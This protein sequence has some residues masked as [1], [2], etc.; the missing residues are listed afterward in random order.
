MERTSIWFIWRTLS[1][2]SRC[3]WGAG[4]GRGVAQRTLVH[5]AWRSQE[6]GN[7]TSVRRRAGTIHRVVSQ[8]F[9]KLANECER[10]GHNPAVGRPRKLAT[11]GASTISRMRTWTGSL[12]CG[13]NDSTRPLSNELCCFVCCIYQRNMSAFN[14]VVRSSSQS[15]G[16][17]LGCRWCQQVTTGRAPFWI[18]V[19]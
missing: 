13:N 12:R 14:S 15:V 19:T 11:Q 9:L 3:T 7:G 10:S 2:V 8:Q 18:K 4:A 5:L 17:C 1:V 6:D 16:W